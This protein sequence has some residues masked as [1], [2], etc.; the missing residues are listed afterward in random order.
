[1]AEDHARLLDLLMELRQIESNLSPELPGRS[2]ES[3]RIFFEWIDSHATT[4]ISAQV[5]VS[6]L[7]TNNDIRD[8]DNE[9]SLIARVPIKKGDKIFSINRKLLLSTETASK[10][11]DLYDFIKKDSIA[12]S[13]Q[14][15]VLVLHLL[16][17]YSKREQSCWWPYLSILP[18]KILSVL[19]LT[20]QSL[21][22]YLL[23]SS[24]IY[25]A[26]KLLRSIARQ[27]SYFYQRLHATRLPMRKDF[28][29]EYYAWGVSCVCSR[30]NEI[31]LQEHT[32][33]MP[34]H[35]AHALIPVLDM[36]NHD[37][38]SNQ[39]IFLDDSSCLIADRDLQP[40]EEIT[41]N[42]SS[43]SRSSGDYYIHNGFVPEI[44]TAAKV[45]KSDIAA[46]V[47]VLNDYDL[48]P[49]TIGLSK[50]NKLYE[51]KAKLLKILNMPTWG[52]FKL[53]LNTHENRHKRD[54]HL[55]MFLIVYS[56]DEEELELIMDDPNP[57]G[58]ADEI[59][60]FVH[61][62][63]QETSDTASASNIVV[64]DGQKAPDELQA[65]RAE[66]KK[67]LARSVEDYLSLRAS[68]SIALID[69]TLEEADKRRQKDKAIDLY[70]IRLLQCE[71][72]IFESY[73]IK[74]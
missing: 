58:I 30:Q 23:A 10:D 49:L 2:E 71:R 51:R 1:M 40:G 33:A 8:D 68:V 17:E 55:T 35:N 13:M 73:K 11:T 67:R 37:P 18:G 14:N 63:N 24:H 69:R 52:R 50:S 4:K 54:P 27:Y 60:E 70:A 61:Y 42:Y 41:I 43:Q 38:R 9:Y 66:M 72:R 16:N 44:S 45:D 64:P 6:K 36:C 19:Q 31:P 59:Y 21:A 53:I 48:V 62:K 74:N 28:T 5:G 7:V 46:E 56:L 47:K 57:V 29:F 20:K 15:V 32:F 39:A 22:Q 65:K 25:E 26:L 3:W 34:Y 12:S